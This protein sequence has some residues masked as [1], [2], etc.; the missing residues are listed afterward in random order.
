M[1]KSKRQLRHEAV[2]RLE[3]LNSPSS[4][5]IVDAITG[6]EWLRSQSRCKVL[7]DLLTDKEPPEG[8]VVAILRE[9]ETQDF[10]PFATLYTK[11]GMINDSS[12]ECTEDASLREACKRIADM[13]ERDYVR[14]DLLTDEESQ[15][16][17]SREKL[18]KDIR[19]F[20]HAVTNIDA[21]CIGEIDCDVIRFI[22]RQAAITEREAYRR[23]YDDGLHANTKAAFSMARQ[24]FGIRKPKKYNL[25]YESEAVSYKNDDSLQDSRVKLEADVRR[26]QRDWSQSPYSLDTNTYE[27][28]EWLDRQAAITESSICEN[29]ALQYG[30]NVDMESRL[31]E[32]QAKCYELQAECEH[33]QFD[34]ES[35]KANYKNMKERVAKLEAKNTELQER[36][37]VLKAERGVFR[38]DAVALKSKADA[39]EAENARLREELDVHS[40][41]TAELNATLGSS[42]ELIDLAHNAWSMVLCAMQGMPIPAEWGDAVER[43]LRKY[44]VNVDEE[45]AGFEM[46]MTNE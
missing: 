20:S 13:I 43:G 10:L 14:R 28:L 9:T 37:D 4:C 11:L 24:A 34:T 42:E 39:L 41:L 7:I 3:T 16:Q 2:E 33:W 15:E 18:I 23:G 22:D 17:D 26:K 31:N 32:L 30:A 36:T 19:D 1:I 5:Q 46:G 40:T 8:D 29:C 44:G 38:D 27:V 45:L 21:K 35:W 6:N 12:L 25:A